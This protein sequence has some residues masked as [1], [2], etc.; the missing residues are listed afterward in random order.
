MAG[1]GAGA[2]NGGGGGSLGGGIAAAQE[3][4]ERSLDVGGLA[5]GRGAGGCCLDP[6]GLQHQLLRIVKQGVDFLLNILEICV[7]HYNG[8]KRVF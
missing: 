6:P 7:R 4:G 2:R 8:M 1:A 3:C 5:L